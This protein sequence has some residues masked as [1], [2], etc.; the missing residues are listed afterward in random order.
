MML[1]LIAAVVIL[2]CAGSWLARGQFDKGTPQRLT[3]TIAAV[4]FSAIGL[5]GV[6]FVV[7]FIIAFSQWGNN[8]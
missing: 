7:F 1:Q 5:V 4:I 2:G 6:G 8:K 3:A